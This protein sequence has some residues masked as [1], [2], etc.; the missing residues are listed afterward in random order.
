MTRLSILI[1]LFDEAKQK[2]DWELC[3][4]LVNQIIDL[5]E[6]EEEEEMLDLKVEK[7]R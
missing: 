1:S 2:K 3:E 7:S 5:H 6:E 4:A